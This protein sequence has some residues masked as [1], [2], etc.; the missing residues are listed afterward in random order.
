MSLAESAVLLSLHTFGMSF[1][2]LHRI[3]VSL[4]T[5]SA[6]QCD[7][8][9]HNLHLAFLNFICCSMFFR[10]KKKTYFHSLVYLITDNTEK[11]SL[12]FIF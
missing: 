12:F 7:L 10:H 9:A 11:S 8:Y 3:V 5:L 1:L 6:C 4:F 2:I